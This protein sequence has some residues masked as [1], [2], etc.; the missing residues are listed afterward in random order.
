[1]NILCTL[2]LAFLWDKFLES[3]LLAQREPTFK[4]LRDIVQSCSKIIRLIYAHEILCH[5]L[6]GWCGLRA[7]MSQRKEHTGAGSA[8]PN[9]YP[10]PF[11]YYQHPD[12]SPP[13]APL[14][15]SSLSSFWRTL[16]RVEWSISMSEGP[17]GA[18][19][20]FVFLV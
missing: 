17:R 12:S 9:T 15:A 5:W 20:T 6:G 18:R 14:G 13:T 2:M 1:M 16:E 11:L 8:T 4:T 19:N 3:E 7:V 10:P